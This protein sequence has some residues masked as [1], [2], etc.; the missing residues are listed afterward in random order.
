[1]GEQKKRNS[2]N[3][4]PLLSASGSILS[5]AVSPACSGVLLDTH[6]LCLPHS[7]W[8]T[9]ALAS[10][11]ISCYFSGISVFTDSLSHIVP[12]AS[13]SIR[14]ASPFGHP[15]FLDSDNTTFSPSYPT[16]TYS[17]TFLHLLN[18]GEAHLSLFTLSHSNTSATRSV[19]FFSF[20]I[21][22]YWTNTIIIYFNANRYIKS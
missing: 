22:V 6:F 1:M 12:W 17:S 8:E 21:E 19:Y 13:S 3:F 14:V 18:S 5:V 7:L 4:S 20:I 10:A 9:P 16:S 2:Q 11:H 15:W